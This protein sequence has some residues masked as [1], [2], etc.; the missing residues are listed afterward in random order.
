MDSKKG[1]KK[2]GLMFVDI[3]VAGLKMSA[4]VDTGAS[5]LFVSEQAA[6]ILDL[7]VEK[8]SGF[9]KNVNSKEA[10]IGGIAKGVRLDIGGWTGK[11]AIKVIPLD[12]FEFVIG[13][14]FLDK[15][16]AFPF[17][18]ADCLCILDPRH[19]FIV[20]A[21]REAGVGAKLLSAIQFTKEVCKEEP[22]FLA[23]LVEDESIMAEKVLDEVGQLLADFRDVMPAELPKSLPP[24]REVDR[25]IELVPNVEPPAKTLYRM[26][27]LELEE[28]RR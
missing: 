10:S 26:A 13:I 23:A 28:L 2:K 6:K 16:N 27:L 18:F 5:K 24:E 14:S 11:E 19:Q 25:K 7:C 22:T 17:P 9:I 3:I 12:Y 1:N 15:I 20:P 4:L 8:A 21:S